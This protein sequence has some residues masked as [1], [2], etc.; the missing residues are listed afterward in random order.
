[1]DVFLRMI[2]IKSRSIA[3]SHA[4]TEITLFGRKSASSASARFSLPR[5]ARDG[6]VALYQMVSVFQQLGVDLPPLDA[7]MRVEVT[8]PSDKIDAL[9]DA[10]SAASW[11]FYDFRRCVKTVTRLRDSRSIAPLPLC[12]QLMQ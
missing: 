12:L 4:A 2:G 10:S 3:Q 8:I 9:I 6:I 5:G 11:T 1:M 7:E